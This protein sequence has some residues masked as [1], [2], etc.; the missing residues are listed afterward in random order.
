MR[1]ELLSVA[2][3]AQELGI[4]RRALYARVARGTV[5]SEMIDGV[6][7]IPATE[8]ERLKAQ[9]AGQENDPVRA[10]LGAP[11]GNPEPK[12]VFVCSA[13]Q[14]RAENLTKAR[15]YALGIWQYGDIPV[16]PHVWFGEMANE[17]ES[18]ERMR[19]RR[20]GLRLLE[21][22]DEV[23]VFVGAEGITEGMAAEIA[24][25]ENLGLVIKRF[26]V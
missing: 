5:R 21:M 8:I 24:I 12:W 3:A 2:H 14:G 6:M 17:F 22:C 10:A 23:H 25:A 19:G 9:A 11:A 13:Y 18:E 4:G 16:V 7:F 20:A 15:E 26:D 1:A